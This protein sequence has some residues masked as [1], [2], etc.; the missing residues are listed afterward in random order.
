MPLACNALRRMSS[1]RVFFPFI[2][3]I[4]LDRVATSTTSVTSNLYFQNET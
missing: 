2:P 1:G 3:A 4:I